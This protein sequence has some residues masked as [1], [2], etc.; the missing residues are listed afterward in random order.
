MSQRENVVASKAKNPCF[1][2]QQIADE[3][4]GIS[5]ERARQILKSE[6]LN[7]RSIKYHK[8]Y[9]CNY[10]KKEFEGYR[11]LPRMFCSMECRKN[12]NRV[13]IIC[14]GCGILF[15]RKVSEVV[16]DFSGYSYGHSFC[17]RECMT[18]WR[19]RTGFYGNTLSAMGKSG[20]F[21]SLSWIREKYGDIDGMGLIEILFVNNIK[22]IFIVCN[23]CGKTTEKSFNEISIAVENG[24]NGKLFYCSRECCFEW[25]RNNSNEWREVCQKT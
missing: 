7:T 5:R 20:Q 9:I 10:C 24:S 1:T 14:D 2:L 17:S 21:A 11:K 16:R 22:H 23:N 6:G 19:I 8:T 15:E 3:C 25:R 4:G 18:N 12:Y 13:E